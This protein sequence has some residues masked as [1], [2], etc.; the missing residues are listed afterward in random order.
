MNL[1]DHLTLEVAV[2]ERLLVRET[3][4]QVQ[5]PAEGGYFGVLPGH[6]PLMSK[7]G[8][9]VLSFDDG[10]RTRYMSIHG[11]V[12][13]VLPDFVRV[14]ADAAEWAEEIDIN[15]AEQARRRANDL[16]QRHDMEINVERALKAVERAQARLEA[17]Q[18][19]K[20]A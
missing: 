8:I 7:L 6:A 3:V 1:P 13:E 20:A 18:R 12:V 4:Q 9:G 16:L 19:V 15:R 10:S 11:G 5:I 14:L 17:S 2:P